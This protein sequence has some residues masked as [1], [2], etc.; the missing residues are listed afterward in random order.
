MPVNPAAIPNTLAKLRAGG[1][2]NIAFFGDSITD[3]AEAGQW[4]QDRSQTYTRLLANGLRA[5]FPAATVTETLASEGG[6]GAVDSPA[7]FQKRVL[8]PHNAGNRVD[9]VVIAMGMNDKGKPS[10][11]PFRQA[12]SDYIDKA[13]AAGIEVLL[14]TPLQSNPYYEPKQTDRVPR[15]QIAAA[16]L[17]VAAAKHATAVDVQTQWNNQASRGI[18]PFSQL[19]NTF[20]HPG[21]AGMRLYANTILR[22]F[23]AT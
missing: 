17:D 2:V 22:A 6:K 4:W 14:V 20:N 21:A 12:M 15:A 13:R 18:A 10:L 19:H 1:N 3:G 11:D 8:D 23:P 7:I 5:R 9:L 16:I